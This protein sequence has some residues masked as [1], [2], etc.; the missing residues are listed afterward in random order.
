[1]DDLVA[2][3]YSAFPFLKEQKSDGLVLMYEESQIIL[4]TIL[5]LIKQDIPTYPMH[6]CLICR[7]S[8]LKKVRKVLQEKIKAKI[9]YIPKLEVDQL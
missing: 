7:K 9:G 1:M 5:E 3:I 2:D 4:T 6:D 8:D